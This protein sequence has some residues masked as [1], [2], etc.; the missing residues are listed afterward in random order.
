MGVFISH[1]LV[2]TLLRKPR[3]LPS[4]ELEPEHAT[5]MA[6]L[7]EEN[8]HFF[9]ARVRELLRAG[10]QCLMHE[11]PFSKNWGIFMSSVLRH[12]KLNTMLIGVM[13]KLRARFLSTPPEL[14][15]QGK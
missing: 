14:A 11:Q 1:F 6:S 7:R 3:V 10:C 8:R 12:N 5:L 4:G 2:H 13:S 9:D 15:S